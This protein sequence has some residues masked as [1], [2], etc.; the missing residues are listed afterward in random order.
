[1][2]NDE[3]LEARWATLS[4][5]ERERDPEWDGDGWAVGVEVGV[6]VGTC[7]G[8]G[9]IDG[10]AVGAG[11]SGRRVRLAGEGKKHKEHKPGAPRYA[12]STIF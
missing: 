12:N 11:R 3:D 1:M 9:V 8:E 6:S 7:D 4:T 5:V 2:T 10:W